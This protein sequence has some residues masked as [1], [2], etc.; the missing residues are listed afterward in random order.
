MVLTG[1]AE[2]KEEITFT[3]GDQQRDFI[4]IEDAVSAFVTV[5][6]NEPNDD[7][8]LRYP[9][10]SG[11]TISIKDLVNLCGKV[12]GNEHTRFSFGT[13]ASRAAEQEMVA[14]DT[15]ALQTL[16]WSCLT[17]LEQGILKTWNGIK[18]R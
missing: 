13:I 15:T 9:V 3:A 6:M 11:K 2:G 7:G 5:A 4:Y 14:C 12:S 8:P 17:S 10:G 16:G 18:A 1:I